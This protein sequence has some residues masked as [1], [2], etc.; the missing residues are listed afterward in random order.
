MSATEYAYSRGAILVGQDDL[1]GALASFDQGS[2]PESGFAQRLLRGEQQPART[3]LAGI[4]DSGDDAAW[5]R[6]SRL[7]LE[8]A[9]SLQRRD[10]IT[11]AAE[12]LRMVVE[13]GHADSRAEAAM[14]LGAL[15]NDAGDSD[16]ALRAW[17]IAE[18]DPRF[19]A[20]VAFELACLRHDRGHE[21][22]LERAEEC[23]RQLI[24]EG[25]DQAEAARYQLG[26]L[27]F[28]TG[29]YDESDDTFAALGRDRAAVALDAAGAIRRTGARDSTEAAYVEAAESNDPK[30]A[31]PAAFNLGTLR[32]ERRTGA[33]SADAADSRDPAG[34]IAAYERALATGDAD[35]RARAL[36][37][38]GEL[39]ADL[40]DLAAAR[41]AFERAIDCGTGE[42]AARAAYNLGIRLQAAGRVEEAKAA[43]ALAETYDDPVVTAHARR[44]AGTESAAEQGFRLAGDN[45]LDG[46]LAALGEAFG[47]AVAE[48]GLA[49]HS[50]KVGL[51]RT[52]LER[53]AAVGGSDHAE[54]SR[55][56][57]QLANA[58]HREG[59][60]V[61]ARA[62]LE[63]VVTTG[64]PVEAQHA[65]VDLAAVLS[66]LGEAAAARAEYTRAMESSDPEPATVAAFN[67]AVLLRQAGEPDAALAMY[68]KAFD[69]VPVAHAESSARAGHGIAEL[70]KERG[71]LAGARAALERVAAMEPSEQPVL[72][73]LR[74]DALFELLQL[75]REAGDLDGVQELAERAGVAHPEVAVAGYDTLGGAAWRAGDVAAAAGWYQKGVAVDDPEWS[76]HAAYNLGLARRQQ[77]EF[78][79]AR[80][81]FERL[82][83][84][85]EAKVAALAAHQLGYLLYN[86]LADPEG[87][88]AAWARASTGEFDEAEV[89]RTNVLAVADE[90][91]RA[92]AD[93]ASAGA[94][95]ALAAAGS[96]AAAV[97]VAE[98]FAAN[99]QDAGD[100]A[101]AIP[102]LRC[103][104]D[105][106]DTSQ[107]AWGG[108]KLG[109][110]LTTIGDH[111]AAR[112]VF[113]R[114]GRG[115]VRTA[116]GLADF[117]RYELLKL[118]ESEADQ[119]AAEALLRQM[120]DDPA[121]ALVR[122]AVAGGNPYAT[123][124]YAT[125]LREIG[126]RDQAEQ[127]LRMV[128]EAGAEAS[129]EAALSLGAMAYE[130]D[131]F[132]TA[133][134][135]WLRVVASDDQSLVRRA[136]NNLGLLAKRRRDL[137]EGLRWF[138]P[139][140][141]A[142]SD[143]PDADVEKA[144]LAAAHLGELCY[145]LEEFD[146]ALRWYL[147]TL[148]G[149]TD[150]ELI[151]EAAYRAGEILNAAGEV[152]QA[153]A[154]LRRA[155]ASGD[156]TFGSQAEALLGKLG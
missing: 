17:E 3:T 88:A 37:N 147:R 134:G 32:H 87:A 130:A 149:T 8:V 48:F 6:A 54:A 122:Q 55:L 10:E 4:G 77:G 98:E 150:P 27:L 36:N 52:E 64:T 47:P 80:E 1:T 140:A 114:V 62:L 51:A 68:K 141:D 20:Q 30:L 43:Y 19:T 25:G 109:E 153:R 23:Y 100:A 11:A 138:G 131:D 58:F 133:H 106:G 123:L 71:D 57:V 155:A 97:E 104:F 93:E 56:G 34:A 101:A 135:W 75:S 94:L 91:H 12:A 146:Q 14:F 102:Y 70:L 61:T 45:D 128:A 72:S 89:A 120:A 113:E 83:D 35:V 115:R 118:S 96:L 82:R 148:D 74:G 84:S 145:W 112:E 126:R 108:L 9:H 53:L 86:D 139:L 59:E 21:T 142:D 24:A 132:D 110:Q 143:A 125:N 79:A 107:L 127:L 99:R 136:T 81:L 49:A 69:R 151:A 38:L 46:A 67:Y 13:L 116:A 41:Q 18:A 95:R 29:R 63:L 156:A 33:D 44:R 2:S 39:H 144:A 119:A 66:D 103:V 121:H 26:R 85:R 105:F 15:C 76:P 73:E 50:G 152:E 28:T 137:P 111:A 129:G 7:A 16:G 65:R 117:Y 5:H 40:G 60:A 78:S 90:L 22:D 42:Y 124:V 92:G 31:G 154:M